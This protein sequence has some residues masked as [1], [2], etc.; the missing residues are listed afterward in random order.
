ML[1]KMNPHTVPVLLK[2]HASDPKEI[3]GH[4]P[5]QYDQARIGYDPTFVKQIFEAV[6]PASA[7]PHVLDMGAGTGQLGEKFLP[8]GCDVTFVEPNARSVAYM[9]QKFAHRPGTLVFEGSADAVS[10]PDRS[11]DLIVMGDASHWISPSAL[12]ELRRVLKPGG[13]MAMFT[14]YWSQESAITDMA[15]DLLMQHCSEYAASPTQLKRDVANMRTRLGRHLVSEEENFWRGYSF[16]QPY[17][18]EALFNHFKSSS[19]TLPSIERDE[20]AFR[21]KVIEPLWD[22]AQ[23]HGL[24]TQEGKM[25]LPY[26]INAL[27]GAPR[28]RLHPGL[29]SGGMSR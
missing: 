21:E 4:D 7:K 18:K 6:A 26:E 13:K 8:L 3:F 22:Y 1:N 23:Q 15:H 5:S 25:R 16:V 19:F 29:P 12:P 9:Q 17:T 11:V 2:S 10:L 14:R 24:I 27:Y 20:K 28:L